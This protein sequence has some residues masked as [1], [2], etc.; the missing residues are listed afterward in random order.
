M[1]RCTRMAA[2]AL[3]AAS[4]NTSTAAPASGSDEEISVVATRQAYRGVFEPL[5]TPAAV[6]AIDEEVFQRAG[7]LDLNQALDLSAS[8]AR[9][10]NFGG[11]W[12]SFAI[13]GLV[14]DEN[15]PSGYLVNGFNAG[16]GF[17]GPRDLSG[18]ERIEILKGPKAAL[19]GRGEPGGAINIV[20]KRPTFDRQAQVR[21]SA[22]RFDHWRADVDGTTPL[23]DVFAVR[24]VG[25][26]E[27]AE[28]FRDTIETQRYG[29][30]P[31]F[32]LRLG[33][34]TTL[35]YELEASHQSL[36]F[37]RGVLAIDG[38]LGVLPDER[39]LGEPGDGPM[40]T[41][42]LGHQVELQHDFNDR[43]SLLAGGGYRDTSLS[44]FSTEAELARNRQRLFVDGRTLSRQRRSREYDSTYAV[45]RGELAGTFDTGPVEHRVLL[46]AD[47]DRF[48]NDQL[49]KRFR[50]PTLGTN[51]TLQQSYAIDIFA[52]VY[53]QF[54]LPAVTPL[55][56]RLEVQEAVGVYLQDQFSLGSRVRLRVGVRYDDFQ[57][58]LEDRLARRDT[59]QSDSRWSP[60]TGIVFAATDSVSLYMAYGEG[61]R[62]LSGADFAGNP[63]GPNLSD[64]LEGGLQFEHPS[65][66]LSGTLAIFSLSQDNNLTSDPVNAGFQITAGEARSRGVELDLAGEP[67]P[68]LHLWLSYA[69]IDAEM[70][71]DVLDVNFGQSIRAGD[72][73]LNVPRHTLNLQVAREWEVMNRT[74][75]FGGGLLHVGTRLGEV[76]TDFELPDYTLL[77]SFIDYE[78]SNHVL[79]RAE[80]D[81]LLD[82]TYYTNSFSQLWVQPGTPLGFRLSTVVTF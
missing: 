14:G 32:T 63:F 6:T 21:F 24:V 80:I 23:N 59:R 45:V 1:H 70:V 4:V 3:V 55:T 43:W 33:E 36:P 5:E 37:D 20:T 64:S 79:V 26:F 56:D 49:F 50:G 17:G 30:S 52:P 71:N 78:L 13:R 76:A 67:L 18:I 38:R 61:F 41:D 19:F 25:F 68:G 81:N 10:N 42:V 35:T 16:R 51:P 8:V 46:G 82:A 74:L 73:L 2:A 58:E 65:S 72:R 44:G 27:D 34:S 40:E 39:F 57:Q 9:Q 62:A 54:A 28:S 69:F 75:T 66:T 77:R 15:L 53:G 29:T 7:A 22:G 31:S 47:A 48:E 11:L 12:N 60:Q